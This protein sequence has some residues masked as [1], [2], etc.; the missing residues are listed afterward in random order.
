MNFEKGPMSLL[1]WTEHGV[2]SARLPLPPAL[3]FA[4]WH[5]DQNI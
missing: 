4:L 1:G 2:P 3:I 5:G